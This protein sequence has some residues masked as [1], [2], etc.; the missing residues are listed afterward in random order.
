MKLI[1]IYSFP[2][3]MQVVYYNNTNTSRENRVPKGTG[4]QEYLI[5]QEYMI[6]TMTGAGRKVDNQLVFHQ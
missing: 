1:R 5:I 2:N 4:F 6:Y 3:P